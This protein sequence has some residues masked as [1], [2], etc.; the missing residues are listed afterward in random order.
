MLEDNFLSQRSWLFLLVI[1]T[2]Q[3]FKNM[4]KLI[5]KRCFCAG[6]E[7]TTKLA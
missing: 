2:L 7:K 6:F 5:A 4:I 3:F 1:Y